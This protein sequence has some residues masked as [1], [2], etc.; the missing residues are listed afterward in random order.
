MA[1]APKVGKSWFSLGVGIEV[2]SG[3]RALGSIPV[4]AGDVLYL[5]LE[6]TG[7]A[8]PVPTTEGARRHPLPHRG[9]P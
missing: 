9:W 7:P 4:D 2:A 3:G 5:A 8:P 6:D 1:G